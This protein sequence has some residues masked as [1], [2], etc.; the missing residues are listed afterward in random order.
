MNNYKVILILAALALAVIV[1]IVFV[2]LQNNKTTIV[3]P[4][5][6]GK[7]G[8]QVFSP[9]E[10]EMISSPLKIIGMV[11]GDGWTG[12]EGQ[13][14]TVKLFDSSGKEL[15]IGILT[16]QGEW[17]QPI[18]DFETNLFFDYPGDGFGNLI[19]YNENASGE[20]ERDKTFILP[21]KLQKSL[22][23]KTVIRAY[24]NN[25]VLD[26]EYSCSKVFP[27]QRE[28]PKTQTPATAALESLLLG[29]TNLE[30]TAGFFTSINTG[31]RI[32]SIAIVGGVAKVDFNEEL[33][34]G[35]AG[36]CRVIAIRA[37]ITETLKQF[38]TVKDVVISINGKTE[39]ILQP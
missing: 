7:H 24:F 19:F 1:G 31:V 35:V 13:V 36:S 14:G 9:K 8:I 17:M 18:I 23:E 21:V 25:S 27:V 2:L 4:V 15:A 10:N 34:K 30:K 3:T 20:P 22:S 33:Q 12:F 28:L 16:A 26:P 39:D 37:Q 38:P 6:D 5:V 32:Q 29:P 11:K